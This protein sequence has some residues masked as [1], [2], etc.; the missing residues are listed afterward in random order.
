MLSMQN[1]LTH[2]LNGHSLQFLIIFIIKTSVLLSRVLRKIVAL[3]FN[4]A[5]RRFI[6]CV[7][8]LF[9]YFNVRHWSAIGLFLAPDF[10]NSVISHYNGEYG[11]WITTQNVRKKILHALHFKWTILI[12]YF[13]SYIKNCQ[14]GT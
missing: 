2:I 7:L 4:G 14:T 5:T 12:K 10:I 13:S 11:Q 3:L 9:R 1:F 8:F 6:V